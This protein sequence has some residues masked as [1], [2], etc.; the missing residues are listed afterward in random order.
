MKNDFYMDFSGEIT[1]EW[2]EIALSKPR[3]RQS[4][5]AKWRGLRIPA[6]DSYKY[7]LAHRLCV[8]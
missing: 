6:S 8:S 1:K 7:G 4:I 2:L 5:E 3:E